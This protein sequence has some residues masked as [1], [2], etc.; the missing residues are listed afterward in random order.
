[1][2]A[3]NDE[4]K[5]PQAGDPDLDQALSGTFPASDPV[6]SSHVEDEMGRRRKV[7]EDDAEKKR[8]EQQRAQANH[9]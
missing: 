3:M 7:L 4:P 6:A 1:M 8:Q 9:Y 5:G 2:D